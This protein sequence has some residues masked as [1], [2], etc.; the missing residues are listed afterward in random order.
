MDGLDI[1][2]KGNQYRITRDMVIKAMR[3]QTPGRIQTYAVD[4][5]GVEFPPKQV[6][7]QTLQIP[8]SDF[9]TTRAQAV[10]ER[11]GFTVRNVETDGPDGD[12]AVRSSRAQA[13]SLAVRL[14]A[15]AEDPDVDEVLRTADS[16]DRWLRSDR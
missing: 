15:G 3:R 11:L 14:F 8:V 9:I 7:A 13:L 2:I 6:L 10:L 1:T 16:F 4:V 5:D 12:V